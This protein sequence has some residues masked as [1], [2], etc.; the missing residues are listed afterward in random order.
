MTTVFQKSNEFERLV[1]IDFPTKE[2]L[3]RTLVERKVLSLEDVERDAKSVRIS[4]SLRVASTA[5]A[6]LEYKRC[7]GT[8]KSIEFYN[9]KIKSVNEFFVRCIT[10]RPIVFFGRHDRNV[11][12]NG[13]GVSGRFSAIGTETEEPPLIVEDY[14]SYDEMLLSA[15]LTVSSNVTFIN[16]GNRN[17]MAAA[18]SS[19]TFEP[20]GVMIGAV[21]TRFERDEEMETIFILLDK[22][23]STTANGYG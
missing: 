16:D 1:R 14:I 15:L 20:R 22:A 17:N 10:K 13:V 2:N 5:E 11:L 6:F 23:R 12:R 3:L 19:G 18:S 7:H 4:A 8:A 9:N 21:G